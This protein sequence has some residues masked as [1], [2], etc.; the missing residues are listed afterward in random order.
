MWWDIERK[1]VSSKIA[2]LFFSFIAQKCNWKSLW[3][4]KYSFYSGNGGGPL[5]WPAVYEQQNIQ[6]NLN[7]QVW[8]GLKSQNICPPQYRVILLFLLKSRTTQKPSVALQFNPTALVMEAGWCCICVC[9][10]MAHSKRC[11]PTR[12]V[13]SELILLGVLCLCKMK[14]SVH[15]F[16]SS[17]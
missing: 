3:L 10:Y 9:V 2:C 16:K 8:C 4:S 17:F 14:F 1:L 11:F 6:F 15:K 13:D 5:F 12:I 7:K